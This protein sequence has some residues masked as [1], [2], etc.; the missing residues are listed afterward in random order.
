M[1]ISVEL[2]GIPRQRA[3]V[4]LVELEVALPTT[5]GQVLAELTLLFPALEG[6]CIVNGELLPGFLVSLAGDRFIRDTATT[7]DGKANLLFLTADA[8]G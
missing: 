3:G 5:L 2:Y 7:L 1:G 4:Q 6:E 8:G